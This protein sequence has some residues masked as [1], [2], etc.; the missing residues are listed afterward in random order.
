[1]PSSTPTSPPSRRS[2]HWFDNHTSV[3]NT[4]WYAIPAL[5][6]GQYPDRTTGPF[7]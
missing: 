2:S 3:S 4:T 7:W 1:M 6:T 5:L